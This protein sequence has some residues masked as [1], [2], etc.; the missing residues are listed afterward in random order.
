MS[1]PAAGGAAVSLAPAEGNRV[2]SPARE[3]HSKAA[4]GVGQ[5]AACRATVGPEL[6]PQL[7]PCLHCLCLGCVPRPPDGQNMV[8]LQ[9]PLCSQSYTLDEL[10]E[11]LFVRDCNPGTHSKTADKCG[12]CQSTVLSG[13]CKECEEGLCVLCVRAH[14]RVRLTRDHSVLTQRQPT[15]SSPTLFCPSH[16]QEP[17]KLFC[18][19][20]DQLTCRDCQLTDHRQHKYQYVSEAVASRRQKLQVLLE[21]L[22]QQGAAVTDRLREN[23]HRLEELSHTEEEIRLHVKTVILNICQE[24]VKRGGHL[25]QEI[26]EHC[27]RQRK[28]V[29]HRQ[30]VLR[31]LKSRQEQ[32]LCFTEMALKSGNNAALLHSH[33]Q[34]QCQLERLLSQQLQGDTVLQIRVNWNIQELLSHMLTFGE[35]VVKEV[36]L[37]QSP[38]VPSATSVRSTLCSSAVSVDSA[39][40]A[41]SV[42]STLCPSVPSAVSVSS[43]PCAVSVRSTVCPSA[44]SAVSGKSVLCPSGPSV[45]STLCPSVPSA[46]SVVSAPSAVSVRSTV[47][48]S[49]PSAVSGK[50]VLCPSGPSVRSTL[51]PS[52]PSAVSVVSAPSAVSVRST[53]C[54]SVPSAVSVASV[55]CAVSVRSTVCPSAPSAVSGKSVLCPSGP[56][57]RST[58][59]PSVPSAVSVVSAPSAVSVRSTLCPSV[60]SAVSVASVTSTVSVRSTLCPSVPS[61]VSVVSAPSA[62]SVR[63]TLCPSVPSTASVASAP[64]AASVRRTPRPIVPSP[65]ASIPHSRRSVNTW[66]FHD[67]KTKLDQSQPR[68]NKDPLPLPYLPAPQPPHVTLLSLLLDSSSALALPSAPLLP[69]SS[70]PHLSVSTSSLPPSLL[71]VGAPVTAL[72]SMP[73]A[74]HSPLVIV[75][76]AVAAPAPAAAQQP[77]PVAVAA[78]AT[79]QQP[80]H[81][82]VAAPVVEQ[83]PPPVAVAAPV[84]EQQPPPVAVAAPVVAQQPP[85]V[86]VAAPAAAQQPPPVAVTAP[87]VAQQPPPVAVAAPVV[88]QQP[89]PVAVAAPVVAHNPPPVAVTVTAPVVGQQPPPVA[90]ADPVVVQQPPPVADPVVAQQPSPVAVAAPVV[91][92]QPSPVAVAVADPVVAQQPPPVAVATP[93]VEQQPLPVTVAALAAAQQPPLVTVAAPAAAQQPPPVTV[94]APAAAQQPPSVSVAAPVAVGETLSQTVKCDTFSNPPPSLSPVLLISP[95]LSS[96][97]LLP[98]CLS[99]VSSSL[100]PLTPLCTGSGPTPPESVPTHMK[101]KAVQAICVETGLV[102]TQPGRSHTDPEAVH[103][104]STDCRTHAVPVPRATTHSEGGAAMS[105]ATNTPAPVLTHTELELKVKVKTETSEEEDPELEHRLNSPVCRSLSPRVSVVRLPLQIVPGAPLPQFRLVTTPVEHRHILQPLEPDRH[106]PAAMVCCACRRPGQLLSCRECDR[107]FHPDC[108]IPPQHS[109]KSEPWQCMLCRDLSDVGDQYSGEKRCSLTVL[110]QRKCEHLLL[111]LMCQDSSSVLHHKTRVSSLSSN[112]I[113]LTLIRGRLLRKLPPP[114]CTP[115]EFVSDVWLLLNT[116]QR[117]GK[118]ARVVWSLQCCFGRKLWEVFGQSLQPGLRAPPRA[119]EGDERR[120]EREQGRWRTEGLKEEWE[121]WQRPLEETEEREVK[122]LKRKRE[123]VMDGHLGAWREEEARP[124][125]KLQQE[126]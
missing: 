73:V 123:A 5:C 69:P 106:P 12:G 7:M 32:V 78:P 68:V 35:L 31:T 118:D 74:A 105:R 125:K 52:V 116:L 87:V 46:V 115:A 34:M 6:R 28:R 25:V 103:G 54:P 71:P 50:S 102:C 21:A 55:P 86:A 22:R 8:C 16:R 126:A 107:T 47:C 36:P 91:A 124:L 94:A 67:Y 1:L 53:L 15:G 58:L 79:A 100:P 122:R 93:V 43:V 83:Q 101:T 49:A 117:S 72:L 2:S 82:A 45:R 64:S 65:P 61:A 114:Y 24:L 119:R 88:E 57:V 44:P 48:P 113:D 56:S 37:S 81:V 85:P 97:S 4:W 104:K 63:S 99:P 51:C 23:D 27:N 13:W 110:E 11:N 108:H 80:P 90:V 92:Q 96:P 10:A 60:P 95:H 111:V 39:P 66:V 19:S 75:P 3:Q 112:Y 20:C 41:A 33:R 14:H 38:S 40:S 62:V 42:R 18:V 77:P 70:F 121:E 29:S 59:C 17:L 30:A 120:S 89:L 76:S 98:P 9:C 109:V 26:K 84:V